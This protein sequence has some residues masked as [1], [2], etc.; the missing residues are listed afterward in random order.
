M[1]RSSSTV[2]LNVIPPCHFWS[3][4]PL[5]SS[6]ILTIQQWLKRSAKTPEKK[7][8]MAFHGLQEMAKMEVQNMKWCF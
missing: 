8:D 3:C 4:Y 2:T 6:N 5:I 1:A 7:K